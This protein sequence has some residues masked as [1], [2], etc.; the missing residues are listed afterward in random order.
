M[1]LQRS[2]KTRLLLLYERSPGDRQLLCRA[3]HKAADT[4]YLAAKHL[5]HQYFE[6][7]SSVG[8]MKGALWH[9]RGDSQE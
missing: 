9:F 2:N 3:T 6:C 1:L 7:L 8:E 5:R 4:N